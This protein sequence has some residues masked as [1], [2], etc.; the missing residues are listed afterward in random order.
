MLS[1]PTRR[2]QSPHCDGNAP[3]RFSAPACSPRVPSFLFLCS[4]PH[5]GRRTPAPGGALHDDHVHV[6]S[7]TVGTATLPTRSNRGLLLSDAAHSV[8]RGSAARHQL[9][10][11]LQGQMAA[12]SNS[13]CAVLA[14]RCAGTLLDLQSY[15][16]PDERARERADYSLVDNLS[17][18]EFR[19]SSRGRRNSS[20]RL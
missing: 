17:A 2:T 5:L 11:S 8:A 6:S 4:L 12:D 10:I 20:T 18:D 19:A 15:I 1:A 7:T 14:A 16:T 9:A 3:W 13:F